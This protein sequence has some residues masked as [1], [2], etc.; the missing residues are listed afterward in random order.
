MSTVAVAFNVPQE[1]LLDLKIS[2]K[3]FSSYAKRFLALDLYNSKGI[4]LGY[5]T[6]LAEM[7][8]EDFTLFLGENKISIFGFDSEAEF[9]EEVG[10]S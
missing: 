8:K 3:A 7:T 10:N 6:D 5:C 4:S 2:E 9:L 1:I